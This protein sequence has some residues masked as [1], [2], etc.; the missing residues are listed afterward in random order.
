[1]LSCRTA[2]LEQVARSGILSGRDDSMMQAA[3]LLMQRC[4]GVSYPRWHLNDPQL[5][6]GTL[7]AGY[8]DTKHTEW[9]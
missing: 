7:A 4:T 1:M 8:E 5:Q 3:V 2:H 6:S 9:D